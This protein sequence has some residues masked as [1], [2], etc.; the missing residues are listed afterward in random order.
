MHR[1]RCVALSFLFIGG[2][3][4]MEN[5]NGRDEKGRFVEGNSY[6]IKKGTMLKSVYKEHYPKKMLEYFLD[7]NEVY[8]TFEGIAVRE[9]L[10]IKTLTRWFA[11]QEKYPLLS[12]AHAQCKAIQLNRLTIDGLTR[13]FDSNLVKFLLENN[14]GMRE[15]KESKVDADTTLKVTIDFFE[16]TSENGGN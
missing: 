8:P 1:N 5:K 14:H 13:K 16:D 7:E 6:R 15:K 4:K 11:D 9:N 10:S 3:E 2:K 12:V